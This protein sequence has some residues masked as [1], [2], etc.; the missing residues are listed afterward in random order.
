LLPSPIHTVSALEPSFFADLNALEVVL[1]G[2]RARRRIGV[3]QA[4]EFV[5]DSACASWSL[6]VLEFIASKPRP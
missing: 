4:A 1:D 2:L 6:K 5:A 3:R